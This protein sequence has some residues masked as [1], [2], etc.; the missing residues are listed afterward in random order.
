MKRISLLLLWLLSFLAQGISFSV[1]AK[2]VLQS[3]KPKSVKKQDQE[4]P[5]PSPEASK[6][7]PRT[8]ASS[9]DLLSGDTVEYLKGAGK[10]VEKIFEPISNK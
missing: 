5:E 9:Q 4:A 1:I 8:P 3:P 10:K 6:E 2:E 7:P